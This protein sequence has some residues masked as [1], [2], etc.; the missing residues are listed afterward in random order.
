MNVIFLAYNLMLEY[1]RHTGL[2]RLD[3]ACPQVWGDTEGLL[4]D[5][6]SLLVHFPSLE[7][8]EILKSEQGLSLD[9]LTKLKGELLVDCPRLRRVRFCMTESDRIFDYLDNVFRGLESCTFAYTSLNRNV[10]LGLLEHWAT[11]TSIILTPA[12]V[13]VEP[14]TPDKVVS[15]KMIRLLLK[16]CGSLQVFSVEDHRMDIGLLEDESIA[17][18]DFAGAPSAVSWIGH[19]S[20]DR[21]VPRGHVDET[22]I[23]RWCCEWSKQERQVGQ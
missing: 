14:S 23:Q 20:L 21:R 2:K 12:T 22:E 1:F 18:M 4:P 11:L 13:N 9:M 5:S 10:L 8:W 3:S 16:S 19:R 6:Q 17:C 7:S 15:S